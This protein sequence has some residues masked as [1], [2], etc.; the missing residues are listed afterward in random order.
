ME[1]KKE[2]SVG[3]PK[4]DADHQI[5]FDLINT[6]LS[7]EVDLET[8]QFILGQ[9]KEYTVEHFAQEEEHMARIDYPGLADHRRKHTEMKDRL[10]LISYQAEMDN[11]EVVDLMTSTLNDWWSTHILIEDMAYKQFES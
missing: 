7:S 11:I 5:I 9:L 2:Y 6:H 8:V 4:F 1:W 3:V 10:D